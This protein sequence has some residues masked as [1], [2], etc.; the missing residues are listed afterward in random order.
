M[1]KQKGLTLW[2]SPFVFLAVAFTEPI[3]FRVKPALFLLLQTRL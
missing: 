1:K 2:R 3:K